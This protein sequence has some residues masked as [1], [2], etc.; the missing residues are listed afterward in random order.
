MYKTRFF[1]TILALTTLT[2]SAQAPQLRIK[3]TSRQE[4]AAGATTAALGLSALA[5]APF[6]SPAPL[7]ENI[8]FWGGLIGL[9]TGLIVLS[10]G[11][12]DLKAHKASPPA[13]TLQIKPLGFA[14]AF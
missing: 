2:A 13:A 8:F 10:I 14:L 4:I 12:D 3:A 6:T 9:S 11:I 1:A 5:A 7:R